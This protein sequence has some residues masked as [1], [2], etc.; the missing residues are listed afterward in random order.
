M[1]A[2][3]RTRWSPVSG[4]PFTSFR[5]S[6][7]REANAS[8]VSKFSARKSSNRH[9]RAPLPQNVAASIGDEQSW[10]EGEGEQS[11]PIVRRTATSRRLRK[12]CWPV[13]ARRRMRASPTPTPLSLALLCRHRGV[14]AHL[15]QACWAARHAARGTRRTAAQPLLPRLSAQRRRRTRACGAPRQQRCSRRAVEAK[16][17]PSPPRKRA[18][19][20]PSLPRHLRRCR[21]RCRACWA[22]RAWPPQPRCCS[23]C[24]RAAAALVGPPSSLAPARLC[25]PIRR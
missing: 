1:L 21:R 13:L 17:A 3:R 8:P 24:A 16:Q 11:G 12:Q 14:F 23:R 25:Q 10:R 19:Y 2:R 9:A 4:A 20:L 6:S 7:L 22:R 18:L 15:R 5:S